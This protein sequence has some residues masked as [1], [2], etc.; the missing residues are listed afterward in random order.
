M[1][2]IS[3]SKGPHI[4]KTINSELHKNEIIITDCFAITMHNIENDK[5]VSS[6]MF[7]FYIVYEN[8][9]DKQI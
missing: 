2:T 4:S 8:I 1:E 6:G 9:S 5:N 3:F 7:G